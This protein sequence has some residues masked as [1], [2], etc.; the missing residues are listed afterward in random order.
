M[1]NFILGVVCC[2]LLASGDEVIVVKHL[3]AQAIAIQDGTGDSITITPRGVQID[4]EG[5]VRWSLITH[6]NKLYLTRNGDII[7]TWGD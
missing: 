5:K 2:V 3:G 6:G 4:T 1:K 7:E